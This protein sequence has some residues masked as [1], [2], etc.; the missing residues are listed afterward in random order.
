MENTDKGIR[1]RSKP[2]CC[3]GKT[4]SPWYILTISET[5]FEPDVA[6]DSGN[7]LHHYM[8]NTPRK[9]KYPNLNWPVGQW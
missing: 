8:G 3:R 7:F 4:C 2:L 5:Y 1:V 6:L 9:F